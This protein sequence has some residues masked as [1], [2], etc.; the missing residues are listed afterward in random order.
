MLD[1]DLS[2]MALIGAVALGFA[3]IHLVHAPIDQCN[4]NGSTD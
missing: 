2:K 4:F 3:Q 1:F